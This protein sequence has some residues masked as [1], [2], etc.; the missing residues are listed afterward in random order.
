[1]GTTA[2]VDL[3]IDGMTCSSC[4]AGIEKK[5]NKLDGVTAT[6]NFATERARVEYGDEVTPEQLVATVEEAGYRAHL[7]QAPID[8][9][10]YVDPTALHRRRLLISA[11]LTAPVIAMAMVPVLQFTDWQWLSLALAVPVVVWGGWPFHRAAVANLRHGRATMDTLISM[12]TSPRSA[13]RSTHCSGA[14]RAWRG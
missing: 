5:L 2:A 13:G 6:V 7:P 14:P 4:A 3:T 8:A 10:D 11:V 9:V 12:G 1:M